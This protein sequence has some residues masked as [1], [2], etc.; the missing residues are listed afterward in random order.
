MVTIGGV[1]EIPSDAAGISGNLTVWSPSTAGFAFIG[2]VMV[3]RPPSSTLNT[4][5]YVSVANGFDVKLSSTTNGRV[6]TVW[7]GYAGS[8]ATVTIDVTGYWK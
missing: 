4:G 5:A 2:P 1:G 7:D 6:A 8:T 3:I